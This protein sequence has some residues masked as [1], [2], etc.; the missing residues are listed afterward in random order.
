MLNKNINVAN[1]VTVFKKTKE[2][3]KYVYRVV[4][5]FSKKY[6]RFFNNCHGFTKSKHIKSSTSVFDYS[7][8]TNKLN[9]MNYFVQIKITP[10]HLKSHF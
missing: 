9:S 10:M 2:K 7:H 8:D 1:A 3:K 6:F 5:Q 4:G